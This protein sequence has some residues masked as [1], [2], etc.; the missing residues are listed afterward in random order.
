MDAKEIKLLKKVCANLTR[1][2][3]TFLYEGDLD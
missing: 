2:T 3:K 1:T